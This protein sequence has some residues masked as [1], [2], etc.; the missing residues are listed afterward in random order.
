MPMPLASLVGEC[1]YIKYVKQSNK[2]Q[3]WYWDSTHQQAYYDIKKLIAC[4]IML[5]YPNFNEVF[6]IYTDISTLQRG[7]VITQGNRPIAFFSRKL[8]DAQW[9]YTIT[10]KELPSIVETLKEFKSILWGKQIQVYTY[11]KNLM[12]DECGITSD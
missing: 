1:G 6:N 2:K 7:A 5:A 9:N 3:K 11:H 12:Q 4:D 8:N 10:E